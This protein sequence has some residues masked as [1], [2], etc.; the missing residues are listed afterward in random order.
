MAEAH[1]NQNIPK[2]YVLAQTSNDG[3]HTDNQFLHKQQLY[4]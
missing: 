2:F 4:V 3:H 1:S